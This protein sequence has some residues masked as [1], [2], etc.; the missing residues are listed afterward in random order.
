MPTEFEALPNMLV[1]NSVIG[2]KKTAAHVAL[3]VLSATLS[4]SGWI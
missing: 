3:V 1:I 4:L 2:P